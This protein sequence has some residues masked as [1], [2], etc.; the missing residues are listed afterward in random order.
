MHS[1]V[2]LYLS[3]TNLLLC[4]FRGCLSQDGTAHGSNQ[5]SAVRF[6]DGWIR[7]LTGR[8]TDYNSCVCS[9]C[10]RSGMSVTDA[11]KVHFQ[12]SDHP[13]TKNLWMSRSEMN[14][15]WHDSLHTLVFTEGMNALYGGGCPISHTLQ[16]SEQPLQSCFFLLY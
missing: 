9:L 3:E 15:L 4:H 6:S 14:H 12:S 13:I 7:E 10:L 2:F 8:F 16:I 1:P 5:S 11:T